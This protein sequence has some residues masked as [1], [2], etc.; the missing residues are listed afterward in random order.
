[1]LDTE[2]GGADLPSYSPDSTDPISALLN[3]TTS[4]WHT[5]YLDSIKSAEEAATARRA[6]ADITTIQA[7]GLDFLRNLIIGPGAAEMINNLFSAVG[8]QRIF[9]LLLSKLPSFTSTSSKIPPP[10][11]IHS[12]IFVIVHIAAGA[13][14]HRA[15]L[16]QQTPLPLALLSL[17]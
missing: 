2:E 4:P 6:Q 9:D 10:E 14:R 15:L 1:M 13:P 11:I 16:I 8:A 17:L 12:T 7:Q 3:S 5:T